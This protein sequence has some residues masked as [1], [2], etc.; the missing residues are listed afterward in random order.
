MDKEKGSDGSLDK[1]K[2]ISIYC[3][4]TELPPEY[5]ESQI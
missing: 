5:V 3:R 1:Y 4:C 2:I